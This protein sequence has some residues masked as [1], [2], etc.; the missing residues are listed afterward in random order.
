M[1]NT[2]DAGDRYACIV[3]FEDADDMTPFLCEN[4]ADDTVRIEMEDDDLADRFYAV[5]K[6]FDTIDE[7]VKWLSENGDE[8]MA[9]RHFVGG[10]PSDADVRYADL[11]ENEWEN[12]K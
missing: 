12:C 8:D 2:K 1:E 7:A 4:A 9:L 6:E 3:K 11:V 10:K 5:V